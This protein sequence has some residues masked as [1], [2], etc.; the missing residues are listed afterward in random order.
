M[1]PEIGVDGRNVCHYSA[2]FISQLERESVVKP[3]SLRSSPRL[4]SLVALVVMFDLLFRGSNFP[5]GLGR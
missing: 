2:N 3:G 5:S 4:P 1:L